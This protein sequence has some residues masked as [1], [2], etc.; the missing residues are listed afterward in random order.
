MLRKAEKKLRP[1]AECCSLRSF[2]KCCC[3]PCIYAFK[4]FLQFVTTHAY[5]EIGKNENLSAIR[6]RNNVFIA[7]Y[8][9]GFCTSAGRAVRILANNALRIVAI[10]SVGDF[11]LRFGKIGV[12]AATVF[13]G[14]ELMKVYGA[15]FFK[16]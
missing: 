3:W 13:I 14:I 9:D 16:C 4:K 7:I 1:N 12:V 2:F 5:I 8:G 11:V 10:N 15:A 6:R